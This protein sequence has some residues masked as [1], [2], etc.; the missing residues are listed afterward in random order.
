MYMCTC[1]HAHNTVCKNWPSI[2]KLYFS[3]ISFSKEEKNTH[4]HN[5]Y[6]H[7]TN[8]AKN[9]SSVHVQYMYYNIYV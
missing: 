5:H 1:V 2:K 6:K 3:L 9:I 8:I 4:T 7:Y